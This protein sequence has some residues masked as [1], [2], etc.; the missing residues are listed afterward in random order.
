MHFFM[1]DP[2]F[3]HLECI[4]R[5]ERPFESTVHMDNV[6]LTNMHKKVGPEDDLWIIGDFAWN[7]A[8]PDGWLDA[9]FENLPGARCHLI[10]GNRDHDAV[11]AL[12]WDTVAD[13]AELTVKD[14]W[15]QETRLV[16]SHYPLMTWNG[17]GKGAKHLFGHVHSNWAGSN[18]AINMGVELWDYAPARI[19]D[20]LKHARS[21]PDHPMF[22]ELEPIAAPQSETAPEQIKRAG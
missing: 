19:D 15:D 9:L 12:P 18:R 3:G 2:H 22:E 10:C 16:L 14:G 11:K 4:K 6:I 7:P 5:F 13:M 20:I 21:L 17:A 8:A 1:A